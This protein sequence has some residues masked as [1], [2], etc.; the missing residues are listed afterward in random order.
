MTAAP[1]ER[2][3]PISGKMYSRSY[4]AA[5]L[6]CALV[7]APM[8]LHAI[9]LDLEPLPGASGLVSPVGVAD[10][11]DGSGRLF[12]VEQGGTIRIWQN[13]ALL[14]TPFL[15]IPADKLAC[16]IERGLLAIAFHPDFATNGYFFVNYTEPEPV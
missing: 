7:A 2:R 10:P 4:L 5:V 3:S 8:T 1:A 9:G 14:P 11:G 6:A 16:C 12:I 15:T 13:G